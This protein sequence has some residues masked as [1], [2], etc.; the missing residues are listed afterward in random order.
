MSKIR[1]FQLFL[2]WGSTIFTLTGNFLLSTKSAAAFPYPEIQKSDIDTV[3]CYMQTS[4]GKI[5]NLNSICGKKSTVTYNNTPTS[6]PN[7]PYSNSPFYRRRA[8]IYPPS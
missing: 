4:D 3:S 7:Y 2:F 5:L 8:P 6:Y 1:Y